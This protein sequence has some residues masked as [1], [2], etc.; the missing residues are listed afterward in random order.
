MPDLAQHLTTD[1]STTRF[2][3]CR[4]MTFSSLSSSSSSSLKY[5]ASH[6]FKA[7]ARSAKNKQ[8]REQLEK[9]GEGSNNNNNKEKEA[10]SEDILCIKPSAQWFR[11]QGAAAPT[12]YFNQ[13]VKVDGIWV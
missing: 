13:P 4:H 7:K 9:S 11:A 6:Q 8:M 12:K 3:A 1:A 5:V 10:P 2:H